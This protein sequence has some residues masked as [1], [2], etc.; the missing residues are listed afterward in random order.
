MFLFSGAAILGAPQPTMASVVVCCWILIQLKSQRKVSS[1]AS[2]RLSSNWWRCQQQRPVSI[3]LN[4]G[5]MLTR[6]LRG[7]EFH[8]NVKQRNWRGIVYGH[9]SFAA[10]WKRERGNDINMELWRRRSLKRETRLLKGSVNCLFNSNLSTGDGGRCWRA[11][12]QF[13]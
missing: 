8:F 10:E 2:M 5:F 6:G 7:F 4:G 3:V 9:V 1:S 13:L 12:Q 11:E